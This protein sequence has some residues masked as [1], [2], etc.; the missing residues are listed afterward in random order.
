MNRESILKGSFFISLS[1]L[2]LGVILKIMHEGNA[3]TL[4]TTGFCTG[5]V[6]MILAIY[7]VNTSARIDRTEKTMWTVGFLFMCLITGIVYL[8]AGR[9]RVVP[10]LR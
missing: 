4:L 7:E 5:L 3:E 1:V 6:F 10:D 2:F 9:K 8:T